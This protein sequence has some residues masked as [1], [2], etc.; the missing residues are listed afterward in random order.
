MPLAVYIL[1]L[2]IFAQGT[3]ELML[4]GLLTEVS[5]DL[6]VS[7]PQAGLLTSAF[8]VGMFL[9]APILAVATVRWSRRRALL[10]FL[11]AFILAHGVAAVTSEYWVLFATRVI[12]AFVYAG[13]WSVGSAAAVGLVA[14]DARGRAMSIFAGGLTVAT[15]V[16]LPAGTFIGQHLGWRAAFWTVAVLSAIVM[17][18]VLL[19][20]PDSRPTEMPR[21]R[22]ELRALATAPVALLYGTTGLATAALI[23]TFTYL[24]ALLTG[25]TGVADGWV[26]VLLGVYGAGALLGIAIGGRTADR[27]PART[28]TV[29]I[30]GLAVT[31]ALL[32]STA[33]H[34]APVAVLVFFLGAFG[35][36][37][38]PVSNSR[39]FSLAPGAATLGA[40]GNVMSFNIGITLGPWLGGLAI[41]AGMGYPSVAWIGTALG[42]AALGMVAWSQASRH[43]P[44]PSNIPAEPQLAQANN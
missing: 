3:S 24:G 30:A 44:V 28:F 42:L 15:I 35:F 17:V 29:G 20:V 14:D 33:H 23:G 37:I 13:F 34:V 18:G 22:D 27:Y 11:A 16:G 5:G 43:R 41:G 40:A 9:G 19:R 2:S 32:A 38:N 10:A 31:S 12:S 1:G 4:A 36:G 8:A 39:V 21:V 6:G 25:T 7:V 26:P